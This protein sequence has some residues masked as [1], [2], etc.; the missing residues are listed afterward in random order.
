ME[1]PKILLVDDRRENILVLEAIL[2]RP[3][4]DIFFA[5][6]GY[7]ALDLLAEHEFALV[8]LDVQM[9]GMSGLETA[10]IMRSRE[11]T[12]YTPI[13]FLTAVSK[14]EQHVFAGYEKGAVDYLPKPVDEVILRGKVNVFVDLYDQKRTLEKANGELRVALGELEESN[15]TILD[16]Q[17]ALVE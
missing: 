3:D 7:E 12:M 6:S 17:R 14:E 11:K 15:R 8:L 1:I 13:I 9:P 2:E 5:T 10:E 16:N 4:L